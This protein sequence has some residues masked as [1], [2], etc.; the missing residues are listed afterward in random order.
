MSRREKILRPFRRLKNGLK[1]FGPDF[2]NA[3]LE[4]KTNP[5]KTWRTIGSNINRFWT[6]KRI[7]Y[8]VSALCAVVLTP[9]MVLALE[10][11]QR[12]YNLD[13]AINFMTNHPEIFIYTC[14]IMF[15]ISLV[16]IAV[17]KTV[18][19]GEAVL[20]ASIITI[21]FAHINKY[22][23][24]D[25]PLL[26]EDLQMATEASE[27]TQMVNL[28]ELAFTLLIIIAIIVG[29]SLLQ[30]FINHKLKLRRRSK[31]S[32]TFRLMLGLTSMLMLVTTVAPV[33]SINDRRTYVKFLDTEIVAWNQV[34]NYNRNGFLV[35]FI[36]NIGSKKMEK[37]TFSEYNEAVIKQIVDKYTAIAKERN[38]TK[39]SLEKDNIDILYVMNESFA[40]PNILAGTYPFVG[41]NP[42]PN[43]SEL[44]EDEHTANGILHGSEYGGGTANVEFEAL[45][46]FS[47][48]F[49]GVVPYVQIMSKKTNFPALPNFL[50]T[51]GYTTSGL[52]PFSGN[53]YKRNIVYK[54]I[55]FDSF[56]DKNSFTYTAPEP[57]TNKYIS[58]ESAYKQ[59]MQQLDKDGKQFVT[60]I[61]MQ[62]HMPYSNTYKEHSFKSTAEGVEESTNSAI[63][64]YLQSLHSSDAA[65]GNL[66]KQIKTR[67]EKTVLVFWGDHLPGL[68]NNLEGTPLKYQTPVLIYSNFATGTDLGTIS[69]NYIPLELFKYLDAKMPAYYHLLAASQ[70]ET[71]VL[72]KSLFEDKSPKETEALKDY[73]MIEY[74]MLSGKRYAEKLGFFKL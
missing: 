10:Y 7:Y 34:E 30:K 38:A 13:G 17:F 46:G 1:D 35:G 44:K 62:N 29:A 27:L 63:D 37:P 36:Y 64:N 45:T 5:Y 42:V 47:N 2:K 19:R 70:L 28:W 3:F 67:E 8:T 24:R 52:H 56:K 60:L 12:L 48:Y 18:L 25:F 16:F 14:L 74:D 31:K 22:R 55:G 6:P 40:D 11:R 23:S 51:L 26:P 72:A 20:L 49:L 53:M 61:T 73:E 68:Y 4:A 71:P 59:A 21:T 50:G 66:V 15:F 69:S 58:D 33:R 9:I 65:L 57:N 54:N 43:L 41:D 39:H 32:A